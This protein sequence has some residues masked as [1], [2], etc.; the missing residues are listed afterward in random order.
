MHTLYLLSVTLHILAA[1]TWVGGMLFLI[2]VVVP[3]LRRGGRSGA[4]RFLHETGVR[5]RDV[6][7]GCFALLAVTGAFNLSVRGVHLADFGDPRWR[8]S[9][10]GRAVT[11]KL[12]LFA[13]AVALSAVHDF[14]VGPRAT[15]ALSHDAVAPEAQRLR[16]WAS[17]L[18]RANALVA[19]ALVVTAVVL[20]RGLG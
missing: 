13:A 11:V 4:A 7:W 15:R 17:R 9:S 6:G 2:L 12:A 19:L 18:G 10:F 8:A 16:G 14:W 3:W 20:V 1:A 5:F